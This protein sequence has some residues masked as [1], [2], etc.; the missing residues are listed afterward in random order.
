M[1]NRHKGVS[2]WFSCKESACQCRRHRRLGFDP[3][4]GKIPWRSKWWPISVFL[5]E[6]FH[7]QKSLVGYSS[8]KCCKELCTTEW[9][10]HNNLTPLSSCRIWILPTLP[11]LST[12]PLSL[13]NLHSGVYISHIL[14]PF[15]EHL[16]MLCLLFLPIC[17]W[18]LYFVKLNTIQPLNIK[19]IMK[20]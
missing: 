18:G 9:L 20:F 16:G 11:S 4:V 12:T 2:R 19:S 15:W 14:L 8:S 7:G 1:L 3:W 17:L 5:S 10:S 13:Q 6:K